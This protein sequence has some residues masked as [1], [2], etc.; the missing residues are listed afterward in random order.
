MNESLPKSS[1]GNID[2]VILMNKKDLKEQLQFF[3][4]EFH[5]SMYTQTYIHTKG[6]HI[7]FH[8][9]DQLQITWVYEGTL[10]Y[11]V[12]GDSFH[13]S[14]DKLLLVNSQLMHSSKTIRQDAKTLCINFSLEVFHPMILKHY[15]VPFL[16]SKGFSY[17]L[18]PL[19]PYPSDTLKRFLD[20]TKS[21]SS[22][23]LIMN[24]LSQIFENVLRDH[25]PK[26][27]PPNYEEI[28]MFHNALNYIYE[29]YAEPLTLQQ[30]AAQ[31]MT[32]NSRISLL[33]KKY[34]HMSPVKFLNKYRLYIAKDMILHTDKP[35]SEISETVG[36]NQLSYFI[37]KFRESYGFSPLKYRNKYALKPDREEKF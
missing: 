27:S 12:N 13:L 3:S 10:E 25:N 22:Y 23:F 26:D 35:I 31:I 32:N 30:I 17:I 8:W 5:I 18:L 4:D 9:H 37:Q 7:P 16:E 20:W 15:I 1:S 21:P 2:G 36:Y 24:F 28:E 6:D 11:C 34:T 19:K 29:H 14:D 33:F